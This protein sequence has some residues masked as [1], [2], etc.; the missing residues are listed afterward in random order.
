MNV[1]ETQYSLLF[2]AT[3][4]KQSNL[5]NLIKLKGS[6]LIQLKY[7]M[8]SLHLISDSLSVSLCVSENTK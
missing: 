5:K 1:V 6:H 4:L 3:L 7:K 8:F 2:V